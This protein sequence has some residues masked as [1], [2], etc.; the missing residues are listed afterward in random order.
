MEKIEIQQKKLSFPP[1]SQALKNLKKLRQND[2]ISTYQKKRK[3]RSLTTKEE[4]DDRIIYE[5][6][7]HQKFFY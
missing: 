7:A 3:L 2:F 1:Q 5:K 4:G 6:G